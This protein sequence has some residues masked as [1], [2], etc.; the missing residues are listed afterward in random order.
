MPAKALMIQGTASNV[1][2]S[3]L[4]TAL[5]RLF[6]REGY[7]VAPF[8]AQNMALNSFSTPAGAEIGRSQAVQAE[9]A[10]V[11]PSV[12]MNPILLKPDARAGSQV[13]VMGRPVG[14]MRPEC[15][16]IFKGQ[17]SSVIEGAYHRLAASHDL[18]IN[19]EIGRASCRERVYVLV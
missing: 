1:G 16:D 3:L 6:S 19:E 9:A 11:V 14:L 5:C 7:A 17:A 12:E 8:K 2:K 4:C 13:I 18:I 15:Y 10:G